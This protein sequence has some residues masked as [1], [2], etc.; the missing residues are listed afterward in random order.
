MQKIIIAETLLLGM[1]DAS[2][3]NHPNKT[4]ILQ[5]V[6]LVKESFREHR[7]LSKALTYLEPLEVEGGKKAADL[8]IH[9]M[10]PHYQD[11]ITENLLEK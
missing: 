10:F 1:K 8:D 7:I 11:M 5:C 2:E 6:A 9:K 4:Q 3:I